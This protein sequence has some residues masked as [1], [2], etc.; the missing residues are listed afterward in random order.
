MALSEDRLLG[1]E[2]LARWHHP[3]RGYVEPDIFIRSAEKLGLISELTFALL[4]VACR[5]AKTWPDDLI[6]S[7]NLSPIQLADSLLPM[8][9]VEVLRE[10][11][12]PPHRLEVEITE[13]ALVS[14]LDAAKS[15]LT[16]F[17]NLGIKVSLDDFGTAYSSLYHLRELHF[18]KIKIDRSFI[19]SMQSNP[20]SE[21]IV[22]AI[23]G[24]T[25][26]LGLPAVAEGIED[27]AARRLAMQSGC[28]IGQGFY[29]GKAVP[30]ADV[31]GVISGESEPRPARRRAV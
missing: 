9:I 11:G 28:E 3:Q 18:D 2:I 22:N 26:S 10:A 5:D 25:K 31:P 4:R 6:L 17:Q 13:S 27:D 23:L 30:A 29:F 24:L 1:F 20:E 21:K 14:D 12:F 8:R 19:L 15:V 16:S 7:L